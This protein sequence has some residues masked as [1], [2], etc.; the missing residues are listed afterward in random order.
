MTIFGLIGA[1]ATAWYFGESAE[2]WF[3]DLIINEDTEDAKL[4]GTIP[5]EMLVP[6]FAYGSIFL[7]ALIFFSII[8]YFM[9]K[10]VEEVGLGSI[11]KSL[12]VAFGLFRGFVL[13]LLMYM[14]FSHFI[15]KEDMPT[16]TKESKMIPMLQHSSE[17]VSKTFNENEYIEDKIAEGKEELAPVKELIGEDGAV[18]EIKKSL[19]AAG[20][21]DESRDGISNIIEADPATESL[22]IDRNLNE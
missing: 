13:V 16:W 3:H 19:K 15:D 5:Y 2:P 21:D 7:I 18:E 1:V 20:Y 14:P 6:S 22:S 12:G 11:D 8:S 4:F 10:S 9:S 17:W